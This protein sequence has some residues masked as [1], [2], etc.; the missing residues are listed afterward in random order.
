VPDHELPADSL[1]AGDRYRLMTSLIVPRPIAWVSTVSAA[2]HRNLAPFSY[3]NAVCSDP[4]TV[5]LGLGWAAD[6]RPK[7]TLA[8]VLETGELTISVVTESLAEAMNH[9][10]GAF[11]HDVD[12][13]AEAGV[14]AAPSVAVTPPRVAE[15]AAALE[16]RL[17]QA[18]PLG[19]RENGSPSTT[20]VIARIVH[21]HVREGLIQ[22]DE[23]DKLRPVD[24][25]QLATV[26]RL[27]G[28][29]YTKTSDRFELVRP[30]VS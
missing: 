22:R 27:A 10:S 4:A 8:N 24:P 21:F 26:G 6:G 18:I 9:T 5:V 29:A 28:M 2:G 11:A 7:D 1:S 30:K 16:C 19:R 14:D 15:A 12:E 23:N 20:L 17:V 13:W 3:F 25:A